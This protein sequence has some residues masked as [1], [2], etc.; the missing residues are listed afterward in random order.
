MDQNTLL[1]QFIEF[2][3]TTFD[4][5]FKAMATLQQQSEQM[6]NM[7]LDQTPWLPPEGRKAVVEWLSAYQTGR[8]EFRAYVESN[9]EKVKNYF[10]EQQ[11]PVE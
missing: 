10:S 4:N 7:I 3:K 2:Q 1:R 8:D 9:F 6:V 11:S 5:S